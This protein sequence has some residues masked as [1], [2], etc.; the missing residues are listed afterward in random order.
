MRASANEKEKQIMNP[1]IKGFLGYKFKLD[2][3]QT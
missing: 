1:S 3:G 2:H